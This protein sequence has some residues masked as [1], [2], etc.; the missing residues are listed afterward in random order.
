MSVPPSPATP[1]RLLLDTQVFIWWQE[2]SDR[3]TSRVAARIAASGDVH[4]SIASAWELAVKRATG[5]LRLRESF[6][7]ALDENRFRLLPVTLEHVERIA[8]MPLHHRDPFDRMLVAQAQ[9]EGMTLVTHD[10][11][12]GRYDVPVLWA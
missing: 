12:I 7:A 2:E 9:H 4:V 1:A 10:D 11:A 6:A 3:L 5:K 8:T